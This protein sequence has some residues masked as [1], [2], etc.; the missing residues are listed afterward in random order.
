MQGWKCDGCERFWD[1]DEPSPGVTVVDMNDEETIA[2]L[3]GRACLGKYV[4]LVTPDWLG[5]GQIE[6]SDLR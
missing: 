1:A 2:E 3:C 5:S 6:S 4:N